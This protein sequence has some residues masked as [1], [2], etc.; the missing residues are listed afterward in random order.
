MAY[1]SNQNPEYTQSQYGSNNYQPQER[2]QSSRRRVKKPGLFTRIKN[3]ISGGS[4][5]YVMFLL[6]IGLVTI[7]VCMILSASFYNAIDKYGDGYHYF[8]RQ[9]EFGLI[10]LVVMLL[11]SKI[12]YLVWRKF[13]VWA[14]FIS[15]ILQVWSIFHGLSEGGASRWIEIGGVNF[16]PSE[17]L[18]IATV[19]YLA[20]FLEKRKKP[21][22]YPRVEGE[23]NFVR[24]FKLWKTELIILGIP[25]VLIVIENWSTAF[26]LAAVGVLMMGMAG[27]KVEKFM[28]FWIVPIIALLWVGIKFG[29]VGFLQDIMPQ[30]Y[31]R[32]LERFETWV[33]PFAD[34]IDTGYQTVQSLYAIGSGGIT[35]V[36]LGKS[37]Q[38]LGFIPDSQ[39]DMIF[40]IICEEFGLVGA[41]ILLSIFVLLIWRMIRVSSHAP[42]QYSSFLTF[43]IMAI[44]ALQ[45]IVN[46]GV[47]TGTIPNTGQPLPFISYGG[48][49]LLMFMAAL[50]MVLNVS[51]YTD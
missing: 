41:L 25:F 20:F 40:C 35:G 2:K 43:G 16:Q 27:M 1:Y 14:Y 47:V 15:I 45:V 50:G 5:D 36:G 38:K 6:V 42:D 37:K 19:M 28:I 10:G 49:S 13:A 29:A 8:T 34:P 31:H 46:V 3:S 44:I 48:T 33:D 18:K 9:L 51:R 11:I 24:F 7:G 26:V 17:L 32:R 4:F 23:S 22:E 39:N 21:E 12:D 30:K